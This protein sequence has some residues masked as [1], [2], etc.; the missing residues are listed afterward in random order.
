MSAASND[1][2][3]CPYSHIMQIK[4]ASDFYANYNATILDC[5]TVTIGKRALFGPSRQS[6]LERAN[7]ITIGGDCWI[8]GGA[9][10]Q[11]GVTLGQGCTVDAGAVVTKNFPDC[12]RATGAPLHHLLPHPPRKN[13]HTLRYRPSPNS[14][15][16]HFILATSTP[17]K[18]RTCARPVEIGNQPSLDETRDDDDDSAPLYAAT[19]LRGAYDSQFDLDGGLC[20]FEGFLERDVDVFVREEE[21]DEPKHDLD[22]NS[23]EKSQEDDEDESTAFGRWFNLPRR[24]ASTTGSGGGGNWFGRR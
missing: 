14:S 13:T 9:N 21:D 22:E 23:V 6:G 8:G 24:S 5:A 4:V 1:A 20:D 17:G 16:R 2:V 12:S 7:E 15:L 11:A 19:H 3:L 18:T 10:I